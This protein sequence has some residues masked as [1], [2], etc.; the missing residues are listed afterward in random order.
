MDE[1]EKKWK[2]KEVDNIELEEEKEKKEIRVNWPRIVFLGFITS[3]V[4]VIIDVIAGLIIYFGFNQ[5]LVYI[6]YFMQYFT[7]GEAGLV[8]FL[9]ACMGNFGQSAAVSNLK[10]KIVGSDPISK[11]SIREATFNAFTYYSA[12]VLLLLYT[13]I[14][15]RIWTLIYG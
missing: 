7:F 4:F 2:N 6:L 8:V 14:L 9:G 10:E 5:D 1:P 3:L 15:W 11:D 12:G 13:T